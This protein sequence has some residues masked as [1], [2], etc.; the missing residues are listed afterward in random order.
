MVSLSSST[1]RLRRSDSMGSESSPKE[2]K[3][4][5]FFK[6][7]LDYISPTTPTSPGKSKIKQSESMSA[8]HESIQKIYMLKIPIKQVV[9]SS[10]SLHQQQHQQAESTHHSYSF[11]FNIRFDDNLIKFAKS[12]GLGSNS[13]NKAATAFESYTHL[14]SINLNNELS[15][16]EI[17]LNPNGN[18]LFIRRADQSI[19]ITFNFVHIKSNEWHFVHIS[20]NE[21]QF[22]N[23]LNCRISYSI[24]LSD[25]VDKEFEIFSDMDKSSRFSRYF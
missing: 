15:T 3:S 20:Y 11:S 6:P 23:K 25:I 7:M 21:E 12:Y 2:R 9:G 16:M 1:S 24:N 18:L 14:F 19:I 13:Q 22:A 4:S 5:G 17:W 8:M 10:S